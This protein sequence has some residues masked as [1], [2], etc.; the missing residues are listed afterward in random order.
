MRKAVASKN[1]IDLGKMTMVEP[2]WAWGILGLILIAVEM[3]SGTFYILWFGIS[4]LCMSVALSLFPGMPA[5]MQIF[6]FAAL[7]L[8]SLA[9]WKATYR[10]AGPDLRVG[11]SQG[12]E[13]GRVGTLIEP[14]GP[15]Q[16]GIIRFAQGVMGSREWAAIAEEELEAGAEAV[17]IGIEGNALRVQ[18]KASV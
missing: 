10:K 11:Q 13:I 12:D 16:N 3:A 7:S 8:G 5:V 1:D 2:I 17:I 18:R 15:R 4:A 9:I 14:A 6:M